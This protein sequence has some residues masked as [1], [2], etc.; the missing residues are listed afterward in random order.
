MKGQGSKL[1]I[2]GQ[3]GFTLIE[4]LVAL[5]IS[6]IIGAGLT[7]TAVQV[8]NVNSLANNHVVAV[9]QVENAAYW[10]NRDV[11]MA[12][13]IQPGGGSGFPLNLSWVEWDGTT[14]QVAYSLQNSDL[15]RSNS[16]NATQPVVMTVAQHISSSADDTNCQYSNGVF[17]FKV[18]ASLS[19]FRPA[20][21]TR[22][23]QVTPRSAQ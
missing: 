20:T 21:E 2:A 17:N 1:A 12:Q 23:A 22:V 15:L 9:K 3:S 11:R 6:G 14:R 5:A 10:L 13:T 16:V 4:I 18:T 8:M 7:M 19:G